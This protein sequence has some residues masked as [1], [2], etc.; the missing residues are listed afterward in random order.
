MDG[1]RAAYQRLWR[2]RGRTARQD[3]EHEIESGAVPAG[4]LPA[5]EA[6]YRDAGFST[7]REAVATVVPCGVCGGLGRIRLLVTE[8]DCDACRGSGRGLLCVRCGVAS[9]DHLAEVGVLATAV[10]PEE[11]EDFNP[12]TGVVMD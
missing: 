12:I 10:D 2:V 7:W 8:V 11:I 5:I 9:C 4:E 1:T 3:G 6:D